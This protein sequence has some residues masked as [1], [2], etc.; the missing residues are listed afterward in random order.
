MSDDNAFIPP[1]AAGSVENDIF[2]LA[3]G[4]GVSVNG[5]VRIKG[6]LCLSKWS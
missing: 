6:C 4:S 1:A 2:Q 3:T 5:M